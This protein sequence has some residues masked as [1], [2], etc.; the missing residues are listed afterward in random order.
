MNFFLKLNLPTSIYCSRNPLHT[1]TIVFS[2]KKIQTL[3]S[4]ITRVPVSSESSTAKS[5]VLAFTVVWNTITKLKVQSVY[6]LHLVYFL[7]ERKKGQMNTYVFSHGFIS[8]CGVRS[9]IHCVVG[10]IVYSIIGCGVI[11]FLQNISNYLSS[12]FILQM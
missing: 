7:L 11:G 12:I 6:Q 9:N 3:P 5:F 1:F 8:C 2:S 4:S 10:G